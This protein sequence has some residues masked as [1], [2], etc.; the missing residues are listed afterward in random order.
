MRKVRLEVLVTLL[1]RD[2]SARAKREKVKNLRGKTER[3]KE[4]GRGAKEKLDRGGRPKLRV[5]YQ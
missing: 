4:K 2:S 5:N 3:K 1:A